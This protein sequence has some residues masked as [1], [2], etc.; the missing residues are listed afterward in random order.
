M[1]EAVE[2]WVALQSAL[3]QNDL[4]LEQYKQARR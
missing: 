1:V 3:F 2:G 4:E